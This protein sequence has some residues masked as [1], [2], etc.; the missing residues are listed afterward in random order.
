AL[1]GRVLEGEPRAPVAAV[2]DGG[3][4][5]VAIYASRDGEPW[6]LLHIE[7]EVLKV[8]SVARAERIAGEARGAAAGTNRTTHVRLTC[9]A[10]CLRRGTASTVDRRATAV[11][12]IAAVP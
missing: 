8:A 3:P 7:Y 5:A 10:A 11:G 4:H 12:D 6:R 2:R 9:A 1:V